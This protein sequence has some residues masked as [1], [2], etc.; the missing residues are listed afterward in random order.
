MP[1][2]GA[3]QCISSLIRRLAPFDGGLSMVPHEASDIFVVRFLRTFDGAQGL[4]FGIEEHVIEALDP[5]SDAMDE[6]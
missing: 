4:D 1:N 2:F 6:S 5:E 3:V